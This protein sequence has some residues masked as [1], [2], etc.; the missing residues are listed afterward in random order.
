M[1]RG[2]FFG[3]LLLMCSVFVNSA[4]AAKSN[5]YESDLMASIGEEDRV[6]LLM[7]H[8]GTSHSDTRGKTIEALNAKA[9]AKYP[10]FDL[11]EAWTS[12][13]I[14]RIM[15]GRGEAIKTPL[16]MLKELK[17]RGYTHVVVQSSN[18]IEGVEM[19]SL[20]RDIRDVLGEFKEVRV[21]NP[22]LYTPEDYERVVEC[23][24]TK[25]PADG[26]LVLVGHGTYTPS[27]AQ[28]A[29]VDYVA[30]E[31]GCEGIFI[32]TIEGY[33]TY[34]TMLGRLKASGVKRVAL[35]PF[36][37]VCGEHAKND[38]AGD[39]AE[40]LT[41]EGFEVSVIMEGL[42]EQVV[43]QSLLMEHI[44]FALKNQMYDIMKKKSEYLEGRR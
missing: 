4:V 1:K 33:P 6:A 10:D 23:V 22:L 40:M 16:E 42:G 26:A 7:V 21:G 17:E 2:A 41:K 31:M 38:I 9:R 8:F 5:F 27:T 34:E 28:Y 32:G 29:M 43:M 44:D 39:W 13:I 18:V 11:Y 19:E 20:R 3:A 24:A 30:R 25:K 14:I 12:R 35:M 36:M 37:F 15:R